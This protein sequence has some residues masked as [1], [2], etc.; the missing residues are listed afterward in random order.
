M[1]TLLSQFCEDFDRIVRP[2]LDPFQRSAQTLSL[3]SPDRPWRAAL[4]GLLDL[5]H[6][7]LTLC[8]KV[9]EQ[10]AYV[11]IFGPLKSGK[12]T[13]MNA[14]ASAYVSEVTSLPAYPCMVYC[15]HS[16]QREFLLTDYSGET[17]SYTD[18]AALR[19]QINRAHGEL[20]DRLREVENGGEDF[21][22]IVHF[23][24]AIRRIDVKVPAG[25][26]ARSGAVLV[27]TPGLYSRMKFGYDRM[28]K[29]FRNSAACAIFIVKSD[30][31]FLEQVFAEF[32]D[33]LNLFSRIFLVV[34]LDSTKMDLKPDGSLVPS[35]EQSDPA[36][37]I[38]AFEN[39]AMS[40]P[41]K[42]AADE[43]KL[44]IYPVDL[45]RAASRRLLGRNG[46]QASD[47]ENTPHAVA[48]DSFLGDLTEYLNSTDY[49]HHFLGDSLRRASTLFEEADT[50]CKHR[51]VVALGA[52]V[53]E[54]DRKA[55][56]IRERVY[57]LERLAAFDWKRG[58]LELQHTLAR[59][60]KERAD[61]VESKT[62]NALDGALEGWFESDASLHDLS[63]G[64]L[65]PV[66]S[67]YQDEVALYVHKALDE[68]V[69][70]GDAGIEIPAAIRTDLR[71]AGMDLSRIGRSALE[72]VEI[73]SAV[74]IIRPPLKTDEIPVRKGLLDWLFFRSAGSV[75]RKLFGPSDRPSVRIP[76]AQKARRIGQA[77]KLA[78]RAALDDYRGSFF[79][80]TV[81]RLTDKILGSYGA[82]AIDR[83]EAE[84]KNA[85][86]V[87]DAALQTTQKELK[88]FQR[89]QNHFTE[90]GSEVE[91]ARRE[92]D[93]LAERYVE[94]EPEDLILPYRAP[95]P[96]DSVPA[97]LREP[98]AS[99]ALE[100]E[101]T[102]SE[103][104]A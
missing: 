92:L 33:L 13:L 29:E 59:S 66:L 95:A 88:E 42:E 48:F 7:L 96:D 52:K 46:R 12:S 36:R 1:R 75:R 58:F 71:A 18:P 63:E 50:L 6:E 17:H 9:A 3:A 67:S 15:S 26:L 5:R 45:L 23:P 62:A 31:L 37:I 40:A 35:L 16:E 80:L 91:R 57:S 56:E 38:E 81:Q 103:T 77:G 21:E 8:D 99:P 54:L 22:P 70:G 100:A 39:L 43:G 102:E 10:Q 89:L 28:T 41:L 72:K 19:M 68:R 83:I 32:T 65:G 69:S 94:T 34:N 78:M 104:K 101:R 20:A 53:E 74:G 55:L 79:P 84:I 44:R 93:G 14:V 51:G 86:A 11:L 24:Q 90:L 76:R 2:V 25:N 61:A 49:L 97:E 73:A 98:L 60:G 4:P 64:R 87:A 82:G 27:D 30:N 85:R 47:A